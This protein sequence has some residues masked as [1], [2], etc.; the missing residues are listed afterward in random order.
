MNQPE[1]YEKIFRDAQFK[2]YVFKCKATSDYYENLSMNQP[3]EYEKIFRDAQFKKYVFKCKA[4][5]DY[6]E[7]S[8][9]IRYDVMAAQLVNPVQEAEK[10]YEKIT[11]LQKFKA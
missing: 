1:E 4:T 9:R 3:E 5:S 6:Y 2:K 10:L 11:E 7:D 8:Q